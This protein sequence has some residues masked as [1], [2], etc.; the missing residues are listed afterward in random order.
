MFVG[1]L[2]Q[3]VFYWLLASARSLNDEQK[4][5]IKLV[6]KFFGIAGAVY[7]WFQSYLS[8]RTQFVAVGNARSSCR[9]LTC[10]LPQGSVLGYLI[11]TTPLSSILRRHNVGYHLYVDDN[12][13]Y[14]SFKST[15]ARLVWLTNKYDHITPVMMQLHW[16]P[17]KE[18]I[19]F[20][21]LLTT[22]KAL[23][24]INP[25][26]LCELISPYQ[27][28]RALRSSDR[29]L[30]EQPA[31]KLKSYGSR[32]FSVCAPGLWN[33]LTLEI[34]SSISVPEFTRRLKTHLFRQ[35]FYF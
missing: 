12:Q 25:L 34:K 3:T 17:V 7:Q 22:F 27:P 23:Y 1:H 14:L 20:K 28:R 10:D 29:L 15:A 19:N 9:P 24:G 32:A 31:Y 11:Y 33:K 26:Y 18:R 35:A 16:L 21:I 5:D 30:L 8:G 4:P 6:I 2:L 13:V